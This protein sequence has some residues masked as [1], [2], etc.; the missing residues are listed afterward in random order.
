MSTYNA[1]PSENLPNS[2]TIPAEDPSDWG[3]EPS[4]G[5]DSTEGRVREARLRRRDL[6]KRIRAC[7]DRFLAFKTEEEIL[8]EENEYKNLDWEVR[9]FLKTAQELKETG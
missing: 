3:G 1:E 6:Q 5:I 7:T 9:D 8:F 4:T 2:V